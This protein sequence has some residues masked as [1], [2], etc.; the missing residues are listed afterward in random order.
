MVVNT[1]NTVIFTIA[2][3]NPPTPG[4]MY[5][6]E[7][8][9]N[10]AIKENVNQINI[11]LSSTID[12]D[13]NPMECEEKRQLLYNYLVDTAKKQCISNNPNQQDHIKIS[14]L[15]VEIICM[16]DEVES[17][18]KSTNPVIG[19]LKYILYELYGYPRPNMNVILVIG[20]DRKDDF[21]FLNKA[22][23]SFDLSNEY[24]ITFTIQVLE[25]PDNAI[26]ATKIRKLATST[27]L[28]DEQE[29]M[30]HMN[31]VGLEKNEAKE[32]LGQLRTNIN[33]MP[34]TKR[35]RTK[36]GK[37]RTYHKYR[38]NRKN[39]KRSRKGNKRSRKNT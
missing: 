34:K 31:T 1:E 37:K 36:G 30:T 28:N 14:N 20:Q 6:I 19:I 4:H 9:I 2:R 29:F 27:D 39:S 3:M 23:N 26:S 15:N 24:P 11:I 33:P 7:S 16:N 13:K 35:L 8:M 22:L 10:L 17:I 5:L 12:T 25:R 38:R 32:L 18:Y 21:V